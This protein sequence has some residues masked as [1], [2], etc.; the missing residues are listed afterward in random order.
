MVSCY[1]LPSYT[2]YCSHEISLTSEASSR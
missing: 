2:V 1:H